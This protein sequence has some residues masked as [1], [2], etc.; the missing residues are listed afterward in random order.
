[1]R[2]FAYFEGAPMPGAI[3][4]FVA[5]P[6]G[7]A[8]T[9]VNAVGVVEADGS[10]KLSTYTAFD[11]APA[12]QYKISVTWRTGGKGGASLIPARYNSAATSGLQ[13]TVKSGPNDVV[14]ELKK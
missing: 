12:N 14:L 1:V 10:F 13:A 5:D 4:T 8:K 9:G 6:V 11:G 2:G 3:V 7:K